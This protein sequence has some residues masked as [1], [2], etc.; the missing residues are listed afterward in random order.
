MKSIL[1]IALFA[2]VVYILLCSLAYFFQEK[3]IF[4]PEKLDEDYKFVFPQD[5]EEIVIRT[6]DYE[7]LHGLLFKSKDSKGL[8]FYLH[9]NAGS[10]AEWGGV[11]EVYTNLQ[12]DVFLLDYRGY[13]KSSGR[14]ESEH[15]LFNDVQ[16]AYSQMLKYYPSN[17][18][19]ILGYSIGTGL[20]ART[21]AENNARMLILQSPYYSLSDVV[22]HAVPIIPAFLLRYKL[23]TFE[24]L[25]RCKMPVVLFHGDKDEVIPFGQ[26]LKLK[27][28]LKSNDVFI[29][30]PGQTHNGMTDNPEYIKEIRK[31]L[32]E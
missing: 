9:G 2:S 10:L 22:K 12:Y 26:S 32:A 29:S 7:N 31:I 16:S 23:K 28:L 8:I 11:A 6:D 5:F 18:I 1:I 19:I 20:A 15:E 30:L 17:K 13:G 4:F 27:P 24:Y 14:I 21:A 3:L 25:R